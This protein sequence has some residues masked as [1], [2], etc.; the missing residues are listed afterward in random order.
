MTD[1]AAAAPTV[2]G[3]IVVAVIVADHRVLLVRR[4]VREGTLSW[5]FPAGEVEFGETFEA[6]ASRE[7]SEEVGLGVA[8]TAILGERVHPATG[9]HMVYLACRVVRGT[10]R[11]ADADELAELAWCRLD[12]LADYILHGV[13]EPVQA[14]LEAELSPARSAEPVDGDQKRT[15]ASESCPIRSSEG[16]YAPPSAMRP[17]N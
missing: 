17:L 13:F 15:G 11:V 4:R 12:E 14:Y 9:R 3:S 1:I 2:R 5:Q 16:T 6:A 7:T 8:P 10:P